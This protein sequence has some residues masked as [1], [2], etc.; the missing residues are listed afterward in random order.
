MQ[1]SRSLNTYPRARRAPGVRMADDNVDFSLLTSNFQARAIKAGEVIF[2]VD[3]VGKELYLVKSGRVE[4]R[5]DGRTLEIIEA[6]GVF[7]E[8]AIIDGAK[9]SATAVAATDCELVP[10]NERQFLFLVGETPFFALNVMRVMSRRL[11]HTT[12]A[13][14]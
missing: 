12:S 1:P 4:I 9:R 10:L 5:V 3:E 6:Q 2:E 14:T 8:M 7:G 11:R 13:A